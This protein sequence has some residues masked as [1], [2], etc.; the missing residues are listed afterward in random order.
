MNDRDQSAVIEVASL[1]REYREEIGKS[2]LFQ[3]GNEDEPDQAFDTEAEACS[4][5]RQ[6]RIAHG[7]NPMTG[8]PA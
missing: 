6:Y 1:D 7:F 4:A 2:W 3:P 8:E 5:Q